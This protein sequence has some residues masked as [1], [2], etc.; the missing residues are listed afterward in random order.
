MVQS[1][2]TQSTLLGKLKEINDL[3]L[4]TNEII[5][6]LEKLKTLDVAIAVSIVIWYNFDITVTC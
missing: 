3:A 4:A 1:P 2:K 6:E 5:N